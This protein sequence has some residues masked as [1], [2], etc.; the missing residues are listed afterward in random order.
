MTGYQF[1]MSAG[2]QMGFVSTFLL[3]SMTLSGLDLW[4]PCA[5]CHYFCEFMCVFPVLSRRIFFPLVLFIFYW[6]L[7]FHLLFYTARSPKGRYLTEP[8]HLRVKSPR[9]L[10][11]CTSSSCGSMY[12]FLSIAWK[13]SPNDGW[14]RNW[15][16]YSRILLIII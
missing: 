10:T 7:P 8:S 16:K 13:N 14:A 5:C 12:L 15:S 4:R 11:L 1:K 2:L 9:F 3:S 6:L